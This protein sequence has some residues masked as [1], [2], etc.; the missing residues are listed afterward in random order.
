MLQGLYNLTSGVL[1]Q[2]RNLNVI[3]NNMVNVSTPGYKTDTMVSTTFRDEMIY[4]SSNQGGGPQIAVGNSSRIRVAEETLVDY[5]Q[6][7]FEET[8]SNLDLAIAKEGFFEIQGAGGNIYSRNG[9]FILDDEGYLSLPGAGRVMG[10][11]GPIYLND[12]QVVI[13]YSG[14][15]R[16]EA[17]QELGTIKLVDFDNYENIDRNKAG[18]FTGDNPQEVEGGFMQ[19]YIEKSN[20]S[21]VSELTKMMSSQRAIQSAAQVIKIYDQLMQKATTEVGRL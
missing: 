8:N 16:N 5:Q 3:S 9:S 7:A 1:T 10:K 12:D 15:I 20:V 13:D 2:N 11:D 17:G 14:T 4:R 6:G 18:Y 21:V 19:G